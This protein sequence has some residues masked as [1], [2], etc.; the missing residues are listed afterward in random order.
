MEG[1][2]HASIWWRDIW[3]L[4]GVGE[5]N[6]FDT[7]VSNALGDGKYIG[8]WK[9]KWLGMEPL[10][11]VYPSLFVKTVQRHANVSNMGSWDNNAWSWRLDWTAPLTETELADDAEL[12]LLL[13][14]VQ[15]CR[16]NE[17]R[18]RWIPHTV[19]VFSVQSAY[20]MLQDRFSL[21]E[22]EPNTVIALKRLWKNNVPSKVI[23]FGWR[24]N[25]DIDHMFFHCQI[26]QKGINVGE[27][28]G[29]REKQWANAPGSPREGD[30]TSQPK[31]LRR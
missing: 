14:Q 31:T 30:A 11:D 12:R 1:L 5:G 15:P 3:R 21:P 10:C 22:I 9:E 13:E 20:S 2:K 8:F 29:A 27:S 4:G 16:D 18:R 7:N 26:S 19:G 28:G 24:E 17:D 23:I 6:W 25:E